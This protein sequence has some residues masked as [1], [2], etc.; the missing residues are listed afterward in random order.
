MQSS[1]FSYENYFKKQNYSIWAFFEFSIKLAENNGIF[2][3]NSSKLKKI[4]VLDIWYLEE[5]EF[6]YFQLRSAHENS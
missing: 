2:E 3:G 5:H 4:L 6:A 1:D